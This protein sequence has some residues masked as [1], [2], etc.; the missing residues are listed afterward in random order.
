MI[1][2]IYVILL[3]NEN[4]FKNYNF[5]LMS[6]F[7]WNIG[8]PYTIKLTIKTYDFLKSK[9]CLFLFVAHIILILNTCSTFCFVNVYINIFN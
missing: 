3:F 2:H 4:I 8:L 9:S 5:D 6:L 7:L 1:H